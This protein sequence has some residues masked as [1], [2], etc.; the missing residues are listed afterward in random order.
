MQID[1]KRRL[2]EGYLAPASGGIPPQE[3]TRKPIAVQIL[4]LA[5]RLQ[6][7]V[8]QEDDVQIFYGYVQ[9]VREYQ[10][11]RL[12][13]LRQTDI[14]VRFGVFDAIQAHNFV[15][16]VIKPSLPDSACLSLCLSFTAYL[17]LSVRLSRLCLS[18]VSSPPPFPLF[19][20]LR[21]HV[22]VHSPFTNLVSTSSYKMPTIFKCYP[23]KQTRV[24]AVLCLMLST[25]S[26]SS[27]WMTTA[28]S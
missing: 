9:S 23:W 16:A 27:S 7:R 20:A 21:R 19:L 3:R 25:P 15:D 11:S 4:V 28:L 5:F 6:S 14:R 13:D 1:S 12:E 18:P 22:T 26:P 8:L 2:V 24:S 10:G 17:C